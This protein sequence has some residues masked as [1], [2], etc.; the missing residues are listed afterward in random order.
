MN[1]RERTHKKKFNERK[2]HTR[3]DRVLKDYAWAS[4]TQRLDIVIDNWQVL[5]RADMLEEAFI[6]AWSSEKHGVPHW[7]IGFCQ[8]VFRNLDRSKLLR[9][10]DV[11]PDGD[12]FTV[13]R[14]VAGVGDK[15]RELGYSWTGDEAI[16]RMFAELREQRYGLPDPAV[17]CANIERQHVLAY[18]NE[19]GRNEQEFLVLPEHLYNLK[20]SA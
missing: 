15:R 6:D 18:I 4:N 16:A 5:R 9:A 14:G 13:Y 10:G 20:K 1:F 17:F 8:M 19:S 2:P 11:M 12:P 7:D 3:L